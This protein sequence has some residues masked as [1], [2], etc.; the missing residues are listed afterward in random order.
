MQFYAK[1]EFLKM[2]IITM[3]FHVHVSSSIFYICLASVS[4]YLFLSMYISMRIRP[5]LCL[6]FMHV[7]V[8][9]FLHLR[10]Y[11]S[12]SVSMHPFLHLHWPFLYILQIHVYSSVSSHAFLYLHI[13][14]SVSLHPFSPYPFLHNRCAEP[15]PEPTEDNADQPSLFFS[16][17]RDTYSLPSP[18]KTI[19]SDHLRLQT[20]IQNDVRIPRL[21]PRQRQEFECIFS[22]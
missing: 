20:A 4:S 22:I 12:V 6:H 2:N 14:V 7:R 18:T 10:F 15:R 13:S 19:I 11:T 3:F 21:P 5:F 16:S 1:L 8:H 17:P 9:P